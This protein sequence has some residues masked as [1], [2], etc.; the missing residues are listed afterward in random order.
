MRRAHT[1]L[2][3]G[4]P[5]LQSVTSRGHSATIRRTSLGALGVAILLSVWGCSIPPFPGIGL[6]G[7]PGAGN[8]SLVDPPV[9]PVTRL[10]DGGVCSSGGEI[11]G[12]AFFTH[13]TWG[14]SVMVTCLDNADGGDREDGVA[15][16]DATSTLRW[17]HHLDG[18]YELHPASPAT[19]A[20]GNL[21]VI[22]EPGRYYGV[23]VL[24]PIDGS[25]SFVA[26]FYNDSTPTEGR[27]YYAEVLGPDP[28]GLYAIRSFF[29]DC[30]PDCATGTTT[31]HVYVW[32][33]VDY[34]R[35]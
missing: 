8:V 26:G 6:P 4:S 30:E 27:F 13:P 23:A 15:V 9:P 21:F 10:I 29:N 24:R 17:V 33:G 35:Q 22:Y 2:A 32:N 28:A 12:H 5:R 20:S 1:S 11:T 16:Y 14:R 25:M 18:Y 34:V 19:D 31:S 7:V 3:G